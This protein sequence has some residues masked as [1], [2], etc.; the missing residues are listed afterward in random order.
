MLYRSL[1]LKELVLLAIAIGAT[2]GIISTVVPKSTFSTSFHSSSST[3]TAASSG[4]VSISPY[5]V[6]A[7]TRRMQVIQAGGIPKEGLGSSLGFLLHTA[8]I[9]MM[10][11]ADFLITQTAQMFE[12]RASDIFNRGVEFRGGGTVCDIMEVLLTDP[13]SGTFQGRMDRA[14]GYLDELYD[15]GQRI[16]RGETNE[17][18]FDEY[19]KAELARCDTLV[20]NDFRTHGT[21]HTPCTQKWWR[22][23]I[24]PYSGPAHGNDIAIHFRWG[25]VFMKA[26]IEPKW[27]TDMTKVTPLVNI[28]REENPSVTVR[29]FLKRSR[30]NESMDRLRE[31]LTPL[32][33]D[34]EIVEAETD[35]E[36]LSMMSK[37]RYFFMNSGSFSEH[38]AATN[39]ADIVVENGGGARSPLSRMSLKHVFDYNRV[40]LA[41]FRQAVRDTL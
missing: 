26:Q 41:Q 29:I 32:S 5:G 14:Q 39:N 16:C 13:S 17:E 35:I 36:E 20:F 15:R 31:I 11:D 23:V 19:A 10:L 22:D 38:A 3:R 27:K 12:Y 25:D 4:D 40:D 34:F 8:N 37:A 28:I 33:G 2:L 9:A 1:R 6:G 24:S 18:L 30:E 7:G 21:H